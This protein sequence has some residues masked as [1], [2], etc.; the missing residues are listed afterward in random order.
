MLNQNGSVTAMLRS[1]A[2]KVDGCRGYDMNAALFAADLAEDILG[3]IDRHL[4]GDGQGD[5][6]AGPAIDLDQLAAVADAELGEIGVVAEFADV[7]VLEVAPH[8]VDDAGNEVVGQR[9][10]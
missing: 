2:A 3:H 10:G 4:G 6:V 8:V 9:P 7:D 1:P 5:G